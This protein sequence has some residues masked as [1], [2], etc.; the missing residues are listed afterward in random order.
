MPTVSSQRERIM[1]EKNHRSSKAK[2]M[3]AKG[4]RKMTGNCKKCAKRRS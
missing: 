4:V 2:T 3:L 1:H